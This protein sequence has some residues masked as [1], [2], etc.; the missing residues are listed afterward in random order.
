MAP[1][2]ATGS[3]VQPQILDD[4]ALRQLLTSLKELPDKIENE[5]SLEE[6]TALLEPWKEEWL[7]E[8]QV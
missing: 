4:P 6:L 8:E 7:F 5:S 1:I 3:G 2:V